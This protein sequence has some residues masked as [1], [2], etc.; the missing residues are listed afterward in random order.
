MQALNGWTVDSGPVYKTSVDWDLGQEN[1]VM[2]RATAL[3]LA[4]WPN[5][6]DGDPFTL[7]SKR[8][9]GGSP[10]NVGQGA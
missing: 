6:T 8:S 3:D 9:T 5:N 4:R 7:N 2:H 1:F 10:A